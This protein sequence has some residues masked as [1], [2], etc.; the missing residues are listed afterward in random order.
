MKLLKSHLLTKGLRK[1][2]ISIPN[3][4]GSVTIR[5]LSTSEVRAIADRYNS[6]ED[7]DRELDLTLR[8]VQ[9]GLLDDKG[10]PM[11]SETELQDIRSMSLATIKHIAEEIS[12]LSGMGNGGDVEK[13]D[14]TK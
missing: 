7:S 12:V 13:K 14:A 2:E 6:S 4:D 9:L 5:E 11:F 3:T 8:I 1:K 10:E